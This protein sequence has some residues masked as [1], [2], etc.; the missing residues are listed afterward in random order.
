MQ[1]EKILFHRVA[2]VSLRVGSSVI[3]ETLKNRTAFAEHRKES[4]EVVQA[5][6]RDAAEQLPREA[7]LLIPL[8]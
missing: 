3:L 1:A 2:V 5:P 4:I 8:G 6:G 7:F